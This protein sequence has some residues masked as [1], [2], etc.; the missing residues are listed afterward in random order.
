MSRE[1]LDRF[2]NT[3]DQWIGYLDK[4]SLEDLRKKPRPGSW[5]LGQ[6]YIHLVEDTQY[7][8]QQMRAALETTSD[9][10]KEMHDNARKMFDHDSFPDMLIEGAST[11]DNVRQPEDKEEIITSLNA[12]RN[13]VNDMDTDHNF[14][15]SKGKSLHP[16]LWFFS[17]AEWLKFTEMHMRHHF[18]QKKRIDEMINRRGDR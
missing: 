14:N 13:E 1:L 18:H 6:V 8:V 15:L 11:D 2:N 9:S 17:A 3:I 4:Y 5:S 10:E 12:I 7:H 16:G